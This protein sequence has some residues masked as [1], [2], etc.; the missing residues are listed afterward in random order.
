MGNQNIQEVKTLSTKPGETSIKPATRCN[1]KEIRK[2]TPI[3][4]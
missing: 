3:A 1:T 4:Q 2:E